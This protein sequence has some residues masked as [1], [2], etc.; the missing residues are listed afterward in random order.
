MSE[1]DRLW[2]PATVVSIGPDRLTVSFK[3]L[4]QCQRCLR[5]EG[6]GAGVFSRLFPNRPTSLVLTQAHSFRTGQRVRVGLAPAQLLRGALMLYGLPLAAFLG[7]ALIGHGLPSDAGARDL[8][9]LVLGLLAGAG[10]L[11]MIGRRPLGVLNPI[12]EPLSCMP[13][14][15]SLESARD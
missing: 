14:G 12:V 8:T 6:C 11:I 10:A 1:R 13:S 5:G 2:Q 3:S 4:S 15:S 9:A 7:G